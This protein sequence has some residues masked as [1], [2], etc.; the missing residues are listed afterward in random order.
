MIASD[1]PRDLAADRRLARGPA[2]ILRRHVRNFDTHGRRWR[3]TSGATAVQHHPDGE[4]DHNHQRHAVQP[5]DD[6]LHN[7]PI[8]WAA[9]ADAA[10]QNGIATTSAGSLKTADQTRRTW[11]TR[12]ASARDGFAPGGVDLRDAAEGDRDSGVVDDRRERALGAR[13]AFER[14]RQQRIHILGSV[15]SHLDEAAR[16]PIAA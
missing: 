10:P 6:L 1:G 13:V 3:L 16:L 8:D 11:P 7:G 4:C 12:S 14:R 15:R 9:R 5:H 2:A